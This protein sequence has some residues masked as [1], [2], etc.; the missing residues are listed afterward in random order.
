MNGI[1][2]LVLKQAEPAIF[3]MGS[4]ISFD[5]GVVPGKNRGLDL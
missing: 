5:V 4:R 1:E 3:C 2:G